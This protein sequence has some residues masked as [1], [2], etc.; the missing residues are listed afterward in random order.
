MRDKFWILGG[1]L[2]FVGVATLPTWRDW[3]THA[4]TRPPALVL[5]AH[6]K[7]CVAPLDFMRGSHMQLLLDWRQS[8]VRENNPTYVAYDGKTY[9]KSLTKTC[10]SCHDK[11][12]F[13]DRCHDYVGARTPYCWNCHVDPALGKGAA[14]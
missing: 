4:N 12:E 13:C 8:A 1:L 7:Q 3:E 6:A 11:R 5:P 2:L 14:R 9:P 10:L